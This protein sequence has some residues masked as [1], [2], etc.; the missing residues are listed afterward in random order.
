MLY[1]KLKNS[2]ARHNILSQC[3]VAGSYDFYTTIISLD[4]LS[5]SDFDGA[6]LLRDDLLN[7]I[8]SGAAINYSSYESIRKYMPI[9]YHEYTHFVDCT[10]TLWGMKYLYM[11][12]KGYTADDRRFGGV[13]S[14]FH[15]TK[16]FYDLIRFSK[17]PNYYTYKTGASDI[18]R[19][20]L[21]Q[22]SI[23]NRFTPDGKVSDYPIIFTR[24]INQSGK[25]IVRSPISTI[26]IL[27]CSAMAQE[28]NYTIGLIKSLDSGEQIVEISQYTKE[29]LDYI[30]SQDLTEYS[31]CAH[32]LSNKFKQK[33]ILVTYKACSAIC[34]YVL[35]TPKSAYDKFS[36]LDVLQRIFGAGA[37][38]WNQKIQK[39]LQYYEPGVLFYILCYLLPDNSLD[40]LE[41]LEPGIISAYARAGISYDELIK[42]SE[43]EIIGYLNEIRSSEIR[44][45]RELSDAGYENYKKIKWNSSLLNFNEL[46]TPAALL[47]DSSQIDF[48]PKSNDMLINIDLEAIYDELIEGQ[49]WTERFVEAC[50]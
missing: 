10:S 47:N 25:I 17:L 44:Y 43:D 41:N 3:D 32:L 50:N 23:G 29:L 15:H 42:D 5:S 49:L 30:Y 11:M 34:R 24:F 4:S 39:G 37:S 28:I 2:S 7:H 19:P 9:A 1:Q 31:V 40:S 21:Y 46:N 20:W 26:S 33:D 14:D 35:N 22:E 38:D 16:S 6:D 45:L 8:D 13:E 27:E 48:F 12:N 18:R 36:S